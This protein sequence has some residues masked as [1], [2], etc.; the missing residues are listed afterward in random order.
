MQRFQ[1]DFTLWQQ[2]Q[3]VPFWNV[4]NTSRS[5]RDNVYFIFQRQWIKTIKIFEYLN[6]LV[7]EIKHWIPFLRKCSLYVNMQFFW[8]E[9][10]IISLFGNCLA[11]FC[12]IFFVNVLKSL[13]WHKIFQVFLSHKYFIPIKN[14]APAISQHFFNSSFS[15]VCFHCETK[16]GTLFFFFVFLTNKNQRTLM[17]MSHDK[18]I[19]IKMRFTEMEG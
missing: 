9:L 3:S 6:K 13:Y 17:S 1:L 18:S 15:F 10:Y 16:L 19:K 12:L 8:Q 2:K 11:R 7:W 14:E 4:Q 5:Y